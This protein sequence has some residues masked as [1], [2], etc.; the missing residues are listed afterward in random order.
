MSQHLGARI[1]WSL[2]GVAVSW[3]LVGLVSWNTTWGLAMCPGIPQSTAALH[4]SSGLQRQVPQL[5]KWN[6]QLLL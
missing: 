4:K 2:I 6:L 1:I 5:I 3:I